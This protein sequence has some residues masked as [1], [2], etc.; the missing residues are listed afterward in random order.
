M[1]VDVTLLSASEDPANERDYQRPIIGFVPFDTRTV[2]LPFEIQIDTGEIGGPSAGL[3]FTLTLID[4]LTDGDLLGGANVAVTG[5]IALDGDVGPHRRPAPEGVRGAP[6]RHR[7]LPRPGRSDRPRRRLARSP[8]TTSSS[9]RS[10]TSTTPLR[11]LKNLAATRC[12]IDTIS[13]AS[14]IYAG[15]MAISFSRPD[16]S[17]PT[18]VADANFPT[19]RR[20]FDQQEVREFL[21]MVAAEMAR[22]QDRERYL[23]GEMRAMRQQ[24]TPVP[25][26]LDDEALARLL[27]EETARIV[28]AARE[29]SGGDPQ[30]GRGSRRAHA[31]RDQGRGAALRRGG[32]PGSG[33]PAQGRRGRR[34]GRAGDGEAAGPRDGGGGPRLPRAGARASSSAGE[35]SPASRSTSSSTGATDSCRRSSGPGSSR[36]TSWPSSCRSASST[37]TST[38]RRPPGRCR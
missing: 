18:A 29:S 14:R 30:Q 9:S 6:G 5:T 36:P 8:A 21:R 15:G 12:P 23:E 25:A 34:R 2:E 38:C 33:P 13:R 26:E 10:P 24:R 11:R 3:A 32:R 1:T 7:L 17:S 28:Q 20:G 22:M 35:T 27:G 31:P 37:S 19:A 4:E 16:P